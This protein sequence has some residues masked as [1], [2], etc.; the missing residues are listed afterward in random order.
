LLF[1]RSIADLKSCQ[2]L[3]DDIMV[4]TFNFYYDNLD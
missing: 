3:E 1:S 4:L 2:F